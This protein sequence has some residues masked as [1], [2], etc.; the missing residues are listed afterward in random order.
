MRESITLKRL[1]LLLAMGGCLALSMVSRADV[2]IFHQ[3]FDGLKTFQ[4]DFTQEVQDRYGDVV[5]KGAGEVFIQRPGKFRWNYETP[6]KQVILG[7]GETLWTYD[8]D[9]EQATRKPQEEILMG[10]P[11]VLLS[12]VEDPAEIFDIA[13]VGRDSEADWVELT[14]RDSDSQ[15]EA[16]RLGFAN[17]QL[18]RMVLIDTFG[19][20]TAIHFAS[21]QRNIELAPGLFRFDPPPGTDVIGE[22]GK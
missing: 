9:L 13:Y 8:A 5:Q 19:Q 16:I 12:T 11:A 20:R 21:P 18:V 15:F 2:E 10:T 7:D 3:F 22:G 6:Y 17:D 4:S 14:P 1:L